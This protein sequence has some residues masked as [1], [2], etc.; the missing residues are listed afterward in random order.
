[1]K[2]YQTQSIS[3]WHDVDSVDDF[4]C[5]LE[6]VAKA[7]KTEE[8]LS[9]CC[10]QPMTKPKLVKALLTEQIVNIAS[11]VKFYNKLVFKSLRDDIS[12][13]IVLHLTLIYSALLY[14]TL[15]Y[16]T[17]LYSTLLHS[18]LPRTITLF[19]ILF[20]SYMKPRMSSIIC[21]ACILFLVHPR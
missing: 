9:D 5:Y 17:L 6:D 20:L 8:S 19:C 11:S 15:L 14:S 16:S 12:V 2:H 4:A 7:I 1:M 3:I 21:P 18:T 10:L 13:R